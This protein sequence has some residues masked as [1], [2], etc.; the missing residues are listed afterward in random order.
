MYSLKYHSTLADR[1]QHFSQTDQI[2]MIACEF[3]RAL[4][5][6]R[7]QD[8]ENAKEAMAKALELL[9]LAVSF[10]HGGRQK[11]MLRFREFVSG[12]FADP[13][14]FSVDDLSAWTKVLLTFDSRAFALLSPQ[15]S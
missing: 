7:K 9:D 1:W 15:Y 10:V 5:A 4:N 6:L 12:F 11:E 13:S 14:L 8:F 2:V 3:N